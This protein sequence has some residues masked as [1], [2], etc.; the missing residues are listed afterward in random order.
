[1]SLHVDIFFLKKAD[2]LIKHVY[3][4]GIYRCDQSLEDVISLAGAV[5]DEFKKDEPG[6]RN[7]FTKSDNAGCY[8][9][10][11]SAESIYKLC[12]RKNINL[13]RYD[14]NEPCCGKDQCD[15][16]SAA[17]KTIVRSY[18]DAG[19]DV[20]TAEHLHKSLHYG[21]G[22][23]DSKVAVAQINIDKIVLEGPKI[24]NISNYHSFEFKE[25]C[26]KMWRYFQVG[27][28]I[29]QKYNN[30]LIEP[31]I[32]LL[33]PYSNTESIIQR[34]KPGNPQKAREDRQLCRLHFCSHFGCTA[35]FENAADI[36]IH[37]LSGLHIIPQEL[38]SMDKVRKTFVEKMKSTSQLHT[39]PTSTCVNSTYIDANDATCMSTFKEQGWAL[40]VRSSFRFS[41][42]QKQL[43]YGYFIHGE[44]AGKKMSPEQVHLLLRK[45]LSTDEYVTSQQIR[46]LFSRWTKLKK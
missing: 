34:N 4:T 36:E 38:S 6:V 9:G 30:L 43:L 46:S 11:L 7:L 35:Y 3:F 41:D 19:N 14:Y 15:R 42:K 2:Q 23:K 20:L 22:M 25:D 1:M 8:H 39:M 24:Q 16:E 29:E 32:D 18:V 31:S 10:N 28:G 37:M 17:A 21:F 26:M 13:V 44:E 33:L 45:K 12:K 27:E 40:P 5:L